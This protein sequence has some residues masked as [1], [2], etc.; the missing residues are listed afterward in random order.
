MGVAPKG[1]LPKAVLANVWVKTMLVADVAP[2]TVKRDGALVTTGYCVAAIAVTAMLPP[3]AATWAATKLLR[4]HIRK[5][6]EAGVG[7]CILRSEKRS[8]Q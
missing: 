5:A 3:P 2:F 4:E 1:Q 8:N 6:T 7:N